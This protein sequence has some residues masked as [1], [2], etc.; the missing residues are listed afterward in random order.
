MCVLL[1]P[2]PM[3]AISNPALLPLPLLLSPP[4]PLPVPP[5]LPLALLALRLPG[6]WGRGG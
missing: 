5:P 2:L 3:R 1:V 6:C 4:L